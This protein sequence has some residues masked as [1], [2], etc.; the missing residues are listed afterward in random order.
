MP[1][2]LMLVHSYDT[3]SHNNIGSLKA[4]R[5]DNRLF[6]HPGQDLLHMVF[7]CRMQ[8]YKEVSVRTAAR[9]T[10][11]IWT[12]NS[13][14][15]RGRDDALQGGCLAYI[16]RH[17]T[18]L[19]LPLL[20]RRNCSLAVPGCATPLNHFALAHCQC[21]CGCSRSAQKPKIPPHLT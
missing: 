10:S 18:C 14:Q 15:L 4:A 21:H 1:L 5:E 16:L 9:R 7:T 3:I 19:Q 6:G 8:P 13:F 20:E 12:G 2:Q 17:V 11:C